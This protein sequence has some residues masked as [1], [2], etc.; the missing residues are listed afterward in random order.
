MRSKWSRV[1]SDG[2]RSTIPDG[3]TRDGRNG[4]ELSTILGEVKN[5]IM[6]KHSGGIRVG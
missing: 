4:V 6:S 1:V 3:F 5:T 2:H